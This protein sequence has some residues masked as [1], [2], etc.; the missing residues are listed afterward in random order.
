MIDRVTRKTR[1]TNLAVVTRVTMTRVTGVTLNS[2]IDHLRSDNACRQTD[3]VT[4][5]NSNTI[6]QE[7]HS[8]YKPVR[9]H[10][11]CAHDGG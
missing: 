9:G 3:K 6:N 7:K 11:I 4:R 1:V 2:Y 8:G 10:D 5:S